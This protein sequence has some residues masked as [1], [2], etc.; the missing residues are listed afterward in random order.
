MKNLTKNTN[1]NSTNA[2]TI[3]KLALSTKYKKEQLD[4]LLKVCEQTPNFKYA[5]ELLLNI[6]GLDYSAEKLIELK[7]CTKEVISES[8]YFDNWH[9]MVRGI[10][11]VKDKI[12]CY[13]KEQV[14]NPTIGDIVCT[15][16]ENNKL[17]KYADGKIIPSSEDFPNKEGLKNCYVTLDTTK[18]VSFS[19][20][21]NNW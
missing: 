13:V 3:E 8:L 12:D 19:C 18:E 7:K 14:K 2:I 4:A 21:L 15:Y 10:E 16:G 1:T 11:I 6:K 20:S 17:R 5:I 9:N